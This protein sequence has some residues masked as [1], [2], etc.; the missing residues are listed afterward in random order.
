MKLLKRFRIQNI[1]GFLMGSIFISGLFAPSVYAAEPLKIG[2]GMALTG[3]LAAAGKPAKLSIEIWRDDVNKNGGIMGRPVE[4]IVYDD[5]TKPSNVPAI[6]G[7]LLDVDKVDFVVSGYGTNLIV[8]AMPIVMDRNMVFMTLFGL[9]ANEKFEYENY[10]QIM[11]S[12]PN[13]LTDWSEGFFKLASEQNP[14]PKTIA[15]LAADSEF[16]LNT[17]KGARMNSKKYGFEI[18]YDG[19]YPPGTPDFTPIVRAIKAKNPDIFYVGSYPPGSVGIVKAAK[20]I[21]LSPKMIGGGM[22]GLQYTSI[23]MNLGKTLNGIVN[24][25]FWA[26]EPTMKF[27]GIEAFLSKYQSEAVKYKYDPLGYYLPPFAYAYVQLLGKAIEGAQSF[28]QQKVA[29]YIRNNAIDTVVGKVSF[30]KNGEWAKSRA[31]QV[32]LQNIQGNS[33]DEFNRAGKMIVLH[34]EEVKSGNLIY[35]FPGWQ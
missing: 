7:K 20:E 23:Q 19:K 30:G 27:T 4:I 13:P 6:Y 2:L 33:I 24:Y 25:W 31:L 14:K 32:Q 29:D 10:F 5:Q 1:V 16:A 12:G 21:D 11:P 17:A 3:G 15:I 35:P 22:V 18:V 9:A 28:E 34:P 8:P 26:P